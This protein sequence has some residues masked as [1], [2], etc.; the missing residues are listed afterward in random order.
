MWGSGMSNYAQKKLDKAN[1]HSI[2]CFLDG[3][4]GRKEAVAIPPKDGVIWDVVAKDASIAIMVGRGVINGKF[5][6]EDKPTFY[7]S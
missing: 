2:D 6:R 7:Y 5:S 1:G 3:F 4:D